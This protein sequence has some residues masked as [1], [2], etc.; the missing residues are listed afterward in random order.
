M[1]VKCLGIPKI[2][3][4]C[5]MRYDEEVDGKVEAVER[6]VLMVCHDLEQRVG[7]S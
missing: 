1:K 3:W 6:E 2:S 7:S 5:G 4:L